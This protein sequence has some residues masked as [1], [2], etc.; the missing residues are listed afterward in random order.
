MQSASIYDFVMVKQSNSK[1]KTEKS[2][3]LEISFGMSN[4]ILL[5]FVFDNILTNLILN[6]ETAQRPKVDL[7][8]GMS[9]F[10]C[11][12]FHILDIL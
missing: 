10:V 8:R 4:L 2:R 7:T 3:Y 1:K 12:D 5:K 9:V 6:F 11:T